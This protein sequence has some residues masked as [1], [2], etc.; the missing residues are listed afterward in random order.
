MIARYIVRTVDEDWIEFLDEPSRIDHKR[1]A[2]DEAKRRVREFPEL[3]TIVICRHTGRT[4]WQS[5]PNIPPSYQLVSVDPSS[6][7]ARNPEGAAVTT[8]ISSH[9][10][11][12]DALTAF[13]RAIEQPREDILQVRDT[14]TDILLSLVA[15]SHA[16]L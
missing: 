10:L 9:K 8:V 15:S 1:A 3:I 5:D 16:Y 12:D 14:A 4:L 11:R 13:Y 7:D 2:W 6:F